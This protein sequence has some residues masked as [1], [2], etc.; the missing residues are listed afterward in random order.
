VDGATRQSGAQDSYRRNGHYK[1]SHLP[2]MISNTP[3]AHYNLLHIT[4]F[5]GRVIFA[6]SRESKLR[7]PPVSS[8][9]WALIAASISMLPRIR[10]YAVSRIDLRPGRSRDRGQRLLPACGAQPHDD[11][12]GA[13]TTAALPE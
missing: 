13:T 2:A 5:E 10:Q 3:V 8:R 4:A 12:E 9:S 1:V 7:N 6:E 11:Q